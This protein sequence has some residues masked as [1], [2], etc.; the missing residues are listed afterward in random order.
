[1]KTIS[2]RAGILIIVSFAMIALGLSFLL[3][4]LPRRS[5][6][7]RYR[8]EYPEKAIQANLRQV[9]LAAAVYLRSHND[10]AVTYADL[11]RDGQVIDRPIKPV[12]GEDY[13]TVRLS[14]TASEV[15]ITTKD[16][17]TITCRF[18]SLGIGGI[19]PSPVGLPP[20]DDLNAYRDM[21]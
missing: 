21:R 17:R 10:E 20:G 4:H 15:E 19:S 16:G 7:E 18:G 9:A 13:R 12:L 6:W 1:M 5:E 14:R 8:I 11:L 3:S 2:T